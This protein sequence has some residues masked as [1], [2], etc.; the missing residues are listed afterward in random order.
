MT[1]KIIFPGLHIVLEHVGKIV[2]IGNFSVAYY[3]IIIAI[4]M[5]LGVTFILR[6]AKRVGISDDSALDIIIYTLVLGVIGARA[7]YV[8]FSWDNYKGDLLSIINI[9]QGGLAIYGG[10]IA[11][12]ITAIVVSKLKKVSPFAFLDIAFPGVAIGQI[13]GR[14]GNFFNR[15][16][17]GQYSSG[18]FRMQ[19]PMD[20]IR[21]MDDVT[22]QMLENVE[23]IDGV[24]YISVHP[25]FLYESVW[26]I[27]VLVIML[28]TRKKKKFD[29]QIVLTYFL[30]Y[31]IGRFLIEGLRTDQL[32]LWGTNLAVSQLLAAL[33]ALVS[34]SLLIIMFIKKSKKSQEN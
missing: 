2:S 7:Y 22:T 8:I 13:A 20:A 12:T 30:G 3:G 11:G 1:E 6:E 23:I 18:L 27:G 34:G 29:G 26:N 17:F 21:S 16:A 15:E 24:K 25:T 14:W 31:G 28:I 9:R 5:V 10:I 33:M 4:G 19:L 32:K